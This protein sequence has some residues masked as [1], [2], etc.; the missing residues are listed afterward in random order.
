MIENAVKNQAYY[1]MSRAAKAMAAFSILI[2]HLENADPKDIAPLW[3]YKEALQE[4]RE[5]TG[6][7]GAVEDYDTLVNILECAHDRADH[8]YRLA[9]LSYEL[10]GGSWRDTPDPNEYKYE[11][12]YMVV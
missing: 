5:Y 1:E 4:F 7:L 12:F 11:D 6:W 9:Q 8:D 10:A 2:S 3:D